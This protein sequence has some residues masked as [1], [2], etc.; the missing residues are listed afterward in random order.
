MFQMCFHMLSPI[1][2]CFIVHF[3]YVVDV[4]GTCCPDDDW[5][6][7]E[8][9][10]GT[11]MSAESIAGK[12]FVFGSLDLVVPPWRARHFVFSVLT[13]ANMTLNC[14]WSIFLT[15]TCIGGH[16]GF[17][18]DFWGSLD[19]HDLLR[20]LVRWLWHVPVAIHDQNLVF[21]WE[22]SYTFSIGSSHL[23]KSLD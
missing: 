9:P 22:N 10:C 20:H 13:K 5:F 18:P 21:S 16:Y 17:N 8:V 12:P 23:A 11:P 15:Y 1:P 3:F 6:A 2:K 19:S 14:I 4:A 7:E